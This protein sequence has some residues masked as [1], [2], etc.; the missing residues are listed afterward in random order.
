M[1]QNF[2]KPT[3]FGSSYV[4]NYKLVSEL[5]EQNSAWSKFL[6]T[7]LNTVNSTSEFIHVSRILVRIGG[8]CIEVCTRH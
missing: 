6:R 5:R 4:L 3:Y 8:T 7:I 1:V 2:S